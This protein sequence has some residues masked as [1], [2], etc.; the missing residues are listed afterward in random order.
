MGSYSQGMT[1]SPEKKNIYMECTAMAKLFCLVQESS[2]NTALTK[3]KVLQEP[4]EIS[5]M[6]SL[7]RCSHCIPPLCALQVSSQQRLLTG[8]KPWE[9]TTP[10]SASP[11]GRL[12]SPPGTVIW[13][14]SSR[15][16]PSLLPVGHSSGKLQLE[17][18]RNDHPGGIIISVLS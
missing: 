9:K 8:Q 12:G 6:L 13:P 3:R 4:H 14:S 10:S 7:A 17:T 15:S 18:H 11:I 1:T 2:Q 5:S 16:A